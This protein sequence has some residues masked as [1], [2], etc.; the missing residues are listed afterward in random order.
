MAT[1]V[2]T[3]TFAIAGDPQ[4][5]RSPSGI[6]RISN[7]RG[8]RRSDGIERLMGC[9]PGPFRLYVKDSKNGC[10]VLYSVAA[11]LESGSW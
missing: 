7:Q 11:F 9:N 4:G 2:R 8:R 10:E 3:R 5:F 1:P 6:V